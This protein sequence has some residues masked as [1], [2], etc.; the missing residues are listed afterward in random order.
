MTGQT[1]QFAAFLT[2]LVGLLF[3]LHVLRTRSYRGPFIML[4]VFLWI[5]IYLTGQLGYKIDLRL[6]ETFA[7]SIRYSSAIYTVIFAAILLVYITEGV[8]ES[9]NV[10]LVSIG[11]QLLLGVAQAFLYYVALPLLPEGSPQKAAAQLIFQPSLWRL[12]VSIFAATVDLFFAVMCFQFLLNRMKRPMLLIVFLA[13]ALAMALDSVIFVGGTRSSTFLTS[14]Q[15][16][17]IFKTA[18]CALLAGPLVLYVAWF[19]RRSGLHLNRGSLD[20]F[21]KLERLEQDLEQAHLELREYA[22]GLERMVEERTQEIQLKQ[23]QIDME[24][25]M[26]AQ[27]QVSLLPERESLPLPHA[28]L[29]RPCSSVSGDLYD[30]GQLSSKEAYLFI[31]DISGH[32]VPSA[33]VGIMCFMAL[34]QVDALGTRPD[35]VLTQISKE[36]EHVSGTHYLTCVFLRIHHAERVIAYANGGH[37]APVI[38]APSGNF[39]ELEATGSLVGL[40][41]EISFE[42]KRAR[43]PAGSR[44]VLY[45]DC[46]YECRNAARE[47]MGRTRFLEI[48]QETR[49]LTPQQ[50]VDQ[51][52]REI[53][54]HVGKEQ[55]DDDLSLIIVDL[56]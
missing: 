16:H 30:F 49:A 8:L 41:E 34:S 37:P 2:L 28:V 11:S 20:I 25:K 38:M 40:S 17:L 21:R 10:I 42:L 26:A 12:A 18:I 7:V 33:L 31:A 51:L 53:V 32:G 35:R 23:Q 13:L 52:L 9:R 22:T 54:A 46:A 50:V 4:V 5:F 43:Y 3:F 56:P 55:L 19:E 1:I 6:T 27:V 29:F 47:E 48:L 24:L 15:S 39:V 36:L 44:L 45:T 14:L